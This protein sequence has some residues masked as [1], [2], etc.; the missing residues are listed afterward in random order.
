MKAQWDSY[1]TCSAYALICQLLPRALPRESHHL[2]QERL[3]IPK[4]DKHIIRLYWHTTREEDLVGK[5]AY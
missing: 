3:K 1:S 2:V 5:G 4:H